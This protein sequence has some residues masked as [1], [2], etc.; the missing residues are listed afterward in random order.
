MKHTKILGLSAVAA[1]ALM[2]LVGATTAS[3]TALYSGT[4]KLGAGTTTKWSLAAS[5]IKESGSTTLE[6]CT[7]SA[8]IWNTS[9][10]GSATETVKGNISSFA[11]TGCTN[12]TITLANGTL[13]IH[14]IPGTINGT[15]T[16][17]GSKVTVNGIFGVSCVYGTNNT[18]LGT[19][20][21][22]TTGAATLAISTEVPLIEGGFLCPN[23]ARWTANYTITSPTPL[24]VTEK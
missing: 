4:T 16:G 23:P 24:H 19:L 15:V 20:V 18:T 9:N 2:A 21:G 8:I 1:M 3:A 7:G 6:T 12:E 14:W 17:T 5:L 10:A 11:W 22:S 13:E